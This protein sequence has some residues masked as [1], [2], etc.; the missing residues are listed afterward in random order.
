MKPIKFKDHNKVYAEDQL[1]Y[2]PLPVLKLESPQG[3]VIA[4]WKMSLIE[5]LKVLFTGKVWLKLMSFN[6]P[7][8]PSYV[9]VHRKE[10]YSLPTDK[11]R[12][13]KKTDKLQ[14]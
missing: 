14:N 12:K 10:V 7:L 8:T 4:C 6:K 2:Q 5:R 1:E 11:E 9:T 3:E 13:S